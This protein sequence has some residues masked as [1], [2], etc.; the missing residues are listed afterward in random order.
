MES[1]SGVIMLVHKLLA[2]PRRRACLLAPL[3]ATF[4]N[5]RLVHLL[6]LDFLKLG[7]LD[8]EILLCV[9]VSSVAIIRRCL[10]WLLILVMLFQL[11]LPRCLVRRLLLP[12][13]CM[14]LCVPRCLGWLLTLHVAHLFLIVIW[15]IVVVNM[16]LLGLLLLVFLKAGALDLELLLK[17]RRPHYLVRLLILPGL[18]MFLFVMC[19]ID[20][21]IFLQVFLMVV[22]IVPLPLLVARGAGRCSVSALARAALTVRTSC[23]HLEAVMSFDMMTWL[24]KNSDHCAPNKTC[25]TSCGRSLRVCAI[26]ARISTFFKI[27]FVNFVTLASGVLLFLLLVTM[28]VLI[29]LLA[30]RVA[31]AGIGPPA[32]DREL[33]CTWTLL[34]VARLR[35]VLVLLCLDTL[36]FEKL[37]VTFGML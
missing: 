21:L 12:G 30:V 20:V 9:A 11:R 36:N 37:T 7:M 26:C 29:Y 4:V 28:I 25:S 33:L 23:S 10:V 31:L 6:Q 16:L 1:V 15:L 22:M 32:T 17:L 8:L 34:R 2:L 13:L 35:L 27:N 14:F 5:T 18:C 3:F 24:L 19:L